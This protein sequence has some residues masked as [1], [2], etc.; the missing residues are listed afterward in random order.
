MSSPD[1][2]VCVC[3][4]TG[5]QG[6]ALARQLRG[7]GWEVHATTRDLGSPAAVAL[8]GIGVRLNECDWDNTQILGDSI[9]GCGKLFL[10]LSPNWDDPSCERRQCQNI[11]QL[12]KGAG[13][14]Q[15]VAPTTIGVSQLDGGDDV[16]PDSFMEK[17]LINKKALEQAAENANF[18]PKVKRYT[19]I[20]DHH[21]WT[22]SMTADA[23]LPIADHEDI[24]KVAVAAFQDPV[25]FH[26][27]AIGVA[28]EQV[29]IREMLNLIAEVAG[30]PGCFEAVFMTDEEMEAQAHM[31]SFSSSHQILQTTSNY[32]DLEELRALVPLN[33]FKDFLKREKDI[34]KQTYP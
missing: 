22:T 15:V 25:A 34:V 21:R 30:K 31:A 28:S 27:R 1:R 7:L 5:Y 24:A 9:K 10:C 33:L 19:K 16:A 4:A 20:R 13:V 11:L 17:H 6:G 32:I 3:S 23:Q 26:R 8:K 18:D 29:R 14:K 2:T 12:A